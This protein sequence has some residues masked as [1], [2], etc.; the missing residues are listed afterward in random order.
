MKQDAEKN[1]IMILVNQ[2]IG[3]LVYTLLLIFWSNWS[4]NNFKAEFLIFLLPPVFY[5]AI[6]FQQRIYLASLLI[7]ISVSLSTLLYMDLN[8]SYLFNTASIICVITTFSSECIFRLGKAQIDQRE[9]VIMKQNEIISNVNQ[10]SGLLPICTS[11]KKIRDDQGNW[12]GVET[13]IRN[14][15]EAEF[16]HSMC[17]DCVKKYYP[18]FDEN[19]EDNCC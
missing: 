11:C 15:S 2:F 14:H 9:K 10:L 16:T 13:F 7:V 4:N 12:S 1:N 3:S 8:F 6:K 18:D 5:S 17:P 19:N